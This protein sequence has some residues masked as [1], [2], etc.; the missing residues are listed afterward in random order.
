MNKIWLSMI[1]GITLAGCAQTK[2]AK[3]VEISGFIEDYSILRPG[4][5]GEALLIY[6]IPQADF[7]MYRAVYVDPVIV[8]LTK[9]STLP[10]E[11]LKKLA[12][13]LRSK[14]IWK[15]KESFLVVP[16]LIPDALRIQLALTEAEPS[17]V[18]MDIAST[19]LPPVGMVSGAQELATGTW[20]FVGKA[21]IEAKVS[22]GN[23]G[24]LLLAAAD[25]RAGGRSLDGSMDSWDDVHQ[26][27]E[28][29][30]KTLSQRLNERRQGEKPARL[31]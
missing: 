16:K 17:D 10:Q 6:Q 29:W 22:D 19:L 13:D 23:T 28:Y 20:A 31:P 11:E 3:E 26:A 12:E 15:M 24:T 1:V 18:G 9:E 8:L 7:S 4:K 21:S 30:A 27:F 25:R 2:Q 14:V 5:D